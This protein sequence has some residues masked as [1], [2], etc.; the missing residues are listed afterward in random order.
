MARDNPRTASHKELWGWRKVKDTEGHGRTTRRVLM[1]QGPH[2][3]FF[4]KLGAMLETAGAEVWRVGFNRGDEVFWGRE[5]YLPYTGQPEDWPA[6]CA[7]HLDR[8]AITDLVLYGDA[9]PIHAEKSS[10]PNPSRPKTAT[11]SWRRSA[12]C[13][14]SKPIAMTP[15]PPRRNQNRCSRAATMPG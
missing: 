3:P 12:P 9:R 15:A 11:C 5:G 10:Q 7:D 1:L 4:R 8:L 2:G 13:G 6:A 14:A